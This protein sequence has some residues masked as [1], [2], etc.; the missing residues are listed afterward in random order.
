MKPARRRVHALARMLA[1]RAPID[2]SGTT[3]QAPPASMRALGIPK[4][5]QLKPAWA[6]V[7]PP[8]CL[9]S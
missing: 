6:I 5:V 1:M 3:S 2:L 7:H 4:T 8:A 9:N